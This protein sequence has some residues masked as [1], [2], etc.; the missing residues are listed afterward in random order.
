MDLGARGMWI[1]LVAGLSMAAIMLFTRIWR[2]ARS[3]R[4]RRDAADPQASP[5]PP[6]LAI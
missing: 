2:T 3:E 4:W 6:G 5:P 1:G